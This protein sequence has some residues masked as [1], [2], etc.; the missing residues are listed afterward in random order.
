M[1][2]GRIKRIV[3]TP[4]SYGDDKKNFP[5]ITIRPGD[6]DS[7]SNPSHNIKARNFNR[8]L[9]VN[10]QVGNNPV[11]PPIK[12][13]AGVI[14]KPISGSDT[15]FVVGGGPSLN[16]FD[17]SQL[18]GYDTIAVNKSV[19]YITNPTYFITTDY[20]Y[21]IKAS[22]DISAINQKCQKSYFVANMSHAYMAFRR[23]QII[24]S[25]RNFVYEDLYQYNGIIQ[26]T[27]GDGFGSSLNEFS[28]GNNSGHCGIQLALLLGYK[29][30]YLLGF[31]L[32]TDGQ[33][34]FH[35]SYREVDQQSFRSRVGGYAN[36]LIN[37]LK[38]L[39]GDQEIINLSAQSIL[40]DCP[41]IKTKSFN[42]IISEDQKITNIVDVNDNSNLDNLMVVGYFTINTPYEQEAQNLLL[43]LNKLGIKHDI[44]GVKTLGNWQANT[45]FKAGFMLDM[46]NKHSNYRL[47]YVDVDAVVHQVPNLFKNYSC[48]I[49]VRWQDFRWRKNECLSGTIYMENN[50]RTKRIC[51]LWRDINVNEGNQSN[52]MEQWNLDTVINKM[53]A[54]D[55][56]FTYK[57]LPPEYTMIFDSMRG[58]YPNIN[59]VIEHFQASRRFKKDVN[60]K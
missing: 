27:A 10:R 57:N 59:P 25:R 33:T 44:S 56:N 31:D 52:R 26:S 38:N 14:E 8:P 12:F 28:H 24:D 23:G 47:L 50:E 1:K 9:H 6:S 54:E 17:F 22:L 35:Q 7:I 36:T 5:R 30:I 51:E 4:D 41:H 11:A 3:Q 55:P 2:R 19:E 13:M 29:K 16:G 20:S 49:A 53:K 18:I 40:N 58:M 32:K 43:S 45:R 60:E 42:D 34:H 39:Q 48:D 21:F 15:C 46:L 37:S